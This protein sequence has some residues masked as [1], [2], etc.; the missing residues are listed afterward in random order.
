MWRCLF[1]LPTFPPFFLWME[2]SFASFLEL[3]TMEP[4][5]D[6]F[7]HS[8]QLYARSFAQHCLEIAF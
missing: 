5:K 3:L 6:L 7:I 2:Q 1:A 4:P 8:L